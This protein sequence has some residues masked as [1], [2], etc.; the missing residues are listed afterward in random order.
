MF[1]FA[2]CFKFANYL[3]V[4]KTMEGD[5]QTIL[6]IHRWQKGGRLV[7][8]YAS[9]RVLGNAKTT[10]SLHVLEVY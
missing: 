7:D 4:A 10:E 9:M 3:V 5:L 6:E 1:S 2:S 8:C